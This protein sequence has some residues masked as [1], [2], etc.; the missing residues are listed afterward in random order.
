M[1]FLFTKTSVSKFICHGPV[2]HKLHLTMSG[3]ITRVLNVA[4]KNDA[5][6]SLADVMSRGSYS[7]REGFSKFN[8]IYEWDFNLLN[9][10]CRMTMTSVSGHLM[11]YE[12]VGT[13]QKWHGCN[14]VMLF[15]API[16][17]YCSQDF[18]NIKRTLER[19]ARQCQ[20]LVI[21]TDGDREG[22]N[23]GYEII[24]TCLNVNARL[25][26]YRA[27]FS[28]ITPR[29]ISNAC[30]DLGPPD[31]RVSDAVD[32]RQELDLRTG[33]AFT[34]FQ[35]LRLKKVFPEVLADSLISFGSCQFPTLGF[36]VERYKQV[37][38]F[39]PETFYKIKVTHTT[40]EGSVD[41]N[42]KRHRLF[43][44]TACLVFYQICMENPTARV[45]EVKTKPKS[46]WRPTPMDTVEL[47]K[48]ASR[49]LRIT[50]KETMKIAEKLYTQGFISYPRTET[51][52]FPKELDLRPLIQQQTVDPNW[53]AF[54]N[55]ILQHGPNP[56]QGKKT[57]NA[58]PPIHP[59]KYTNTLS[60]NESRVYELVVRHFLACCSQDAQGR[61]TT[62]EIDIAE[63]RFTVQGIMIIAR[64][65]LD[66]YP[67]DK[68]NAKVIPVFQQGE[69]FQPT[70]I[71]MVDGETSPP[72]LLTEADLI[73]LM[74]KHGIGTDA[75]HADHIDTIKSRNYVGL[76]N[77]SRFVP[78]ELGIG[79]VDGYNNMGYELA[80]PDLR[81]AFEAELVEICEGRKDRDN[82]LREQIAKYK[83]V[84]VEAVEKANRLDEAL[85]EYFGEA[86]QYTAD[87][88]QHSDISMP[89]RPCPHCNKA[90][91]I[92]SKKDGGQMLSCTGFPDCKTAV[93]FPASVEKASL[94]DSI[95]S[96]CQPGPV[97]KIKFKFRRGSVPP[98]Y[99][100][101]YICCIGGCDTALTELGFN[102][103]YLR[104]NTSSGST[105]RQ[106][107][108]QRGGRSRI[109]SGR[110][111]FGSQDSGY[112]SSFT[113]SGNSTRTPGFLSTGQRGGG[114]SQRGRGRGGGAGR[115][116][117][118]QGMDRQPL[119]S[120]A[121]RFNT[122]NSSDSAIVCNCNEDARIL[123][124]RKE[125]PNCGRQFYKCANGACDFFLWAESD[126]T[127]TNTSNSLP[128]WGGSGFGN[129]SN[130]RG[131]NSDTQRGSSANAW[132]E[133]V[134]RCNQPAVKRTV[135][136]EGPNK[137]RE[138][139]TCPKP[140]DNQC[141]F[142]E[143]TDGVGNTNAGFG[144]N[145]RGF[146]N[147]GR[148]RGGQ[149][150]NWNSRNENDG[151]GNP[152]KRK[153]VTC[154]ICGQEGHTRRTC[155]QR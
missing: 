89:V 142:F 13:Y 56:R 7:R 97:H 71:E 132:G 50:A 16:E 82:V 113:S 101:E 78:G 62:V 48:L 126:T 91:V 58:H 87:E 137:G 105:S 17:K 102:L 92:K 8:K 85:S 45:I 23:I 117:P 14:P 5:A 155:P 144:G 90:M 35:T 64:N 103:S 152:K 41:F 108:S 61:E 136:K 30:R 31:R 25:K 123:T 153:T 19:E 150:S 51:N 18:Q 75:T 145:S 49:K 95:C 65:Y 59:I 77:D 111:S 109:P 9:Q 47:E 70:A 120:I 133:V 106:N 124:V 11:N 1:I 24:D 84:F 154:G 94:E 36:V 80:K 110:S 54:A 21:W 74:E 32:V 135:Q 149:R 2:I 93:W 27:R 86:H 119:G 42:W 151:G 116:G 28:E 128:S 83:S 57:D 73:S 53:G 29:S 79:L 33:A 143:W 98:G 10:N 88:I 55:G 129:S 44:H 63:E 104:T 46:R 140:R 138:F 68:W 118:S 147:S 127:A 146:G 6:K 125:G 96:Q 131:G 115:G 20:I 114:S 112:N 139:W 67:Y 4:E 66:V 12:F 43:D 99:P 38:N 52:I 3:R 15:D 148:G 141:G 81:A 37:K 39:I 22:E 130:E 40:D 34:R 122:N 26:V 121:S 69:E 107:S 60:G 72:P 100:A 76:T 134:C